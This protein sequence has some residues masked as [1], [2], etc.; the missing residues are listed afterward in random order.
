MSSRKVT[1]APKL[2]PK[3]LL[4]NKITSYVGKPSS[5]RLSEKSV[6]CIASKK[7]K[8][9]RKTV[10]PLYLT[11]H[12]LLSIALIKPAWHWPAVS[13]IFKKGKNN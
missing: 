3:S 1:I 6:T 2:V 4:N 11:R 5:K 12:S 7:Q 10:L 9:T 13:A 8:K